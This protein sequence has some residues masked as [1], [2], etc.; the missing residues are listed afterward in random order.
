MN[1]PGFTLLRGGEGLGFDIEGTL[2]L[3]AGVMDGEGD[4]VAGGIATV[5]GR[6]QQNI[7]ANCTHNGWC[8]SGRSAGFQKNFH[9]GSLAGISSLTQ[10]SNFHDLFGQ[11]IVILVID[12]ICGSSGLISS[13]KNRVFAK[14]IGLSFDIGRQLNTELLQILANANVVGFAV[15]KV[16]I[17]VQVMG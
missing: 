14:N 13:V 17:S 7:F 5:A 15:V 2:L 6:D 9:I 8:I 16:E 3:L 12:R 10:H 11:G 1:L 4:L